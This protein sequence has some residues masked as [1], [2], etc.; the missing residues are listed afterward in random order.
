MPRAVVWFK[1]DLRV[2]DHAPLA[3]AAERG[4]VVGLYVHEPEILTSPEWSPGHLAFI[5]DCL[6]Q[7]RDRLASLGSIL[8]TRHG[9]MPDTLDRLHDQWRFEELWSHEETGLSIT[10]ARDRRV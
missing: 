8:L 1:R 10:Y 3:E 5:E 2:A 6:G 4:P 7:L 9:A